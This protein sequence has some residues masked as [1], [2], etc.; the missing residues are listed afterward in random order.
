M[1]SAVAQQHGQSHSAPAPAAQLFMTDHWDPA[2]GRPWS[3]QAAPGQLGILRA[4]SGVHG[5]AASASGLAGVD[6]TCLRACELHRGWNPAPACHMLCETEAQPAP[7]PAAGGWSTDGVPP[8]TPTALYGCLK[9]C[10]DTRTPADQQM[11]RLGCSIATGAPGYMRS[12]AGGCTKL[13]MDQCVAS[14]GLPYGACSSRCTA[15]CTGSVEESVVT[16]APPRE[17]Y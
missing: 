7:V 15:A 14:G 9:Q 4:I 3:S 8:Y 17:Y 5:L 2:T 16:R 12:A 10:T 1:D 11:C 6:A 13:C